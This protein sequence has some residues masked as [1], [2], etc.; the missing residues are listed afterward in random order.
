MNVGYTPAP[1]NTNQNRPTPRPGNPPLSSPP[2]GSPAAHQRPPFPGRGA[3]IRPVA[4]FSGVQRPRPINAAPQHPPAS[5]RPQGQ[6]PTMQQQQQ[7]QQQPPVANQM[8]N[9]ASIATGMQNMNLQPNPGP[10]QMLPPQVQPPHHHRAKRVYATAPEIPAVSQKS[11]LA[12]SQAPAPWPHGLSQQPQQSP[13]RPVQQPRAQQQ[14]VD[15]NIIPSQQV[16]PRVDPDQMPAP[17]QVREYDQNLHG[18]KFIGTCDREHTPLTTTDFLAMDQGNCNPRFMRSV[19]NSMPR[20]KELADVSALPMGL[21]VQPLAALARE[22]DPIQVVDHGPEGPVR[23]TRC[24]AY[25]NPWC[26]FTQGGNRF[27]CNIC[28][29]NSEVPPSYFSNLDVSG[30][31]M[32]LDQRPELKFGSVEFDVPDLYY[33]SRT[34][35]SISHLFAIDVSANAIKS[36][37]TATVCEALRKSL[38]DIDPSS[39][40]LPKDARIGIMTYDYGVHFY[41]VHPEC[42]QAK[43]L[44]VGEVADM[45]VPLQDGMLV[46]P[47]DSKDIISELLQNIPSMFA[48]NQRG[49]S[50]YSSAV[51]GGMQALSVTGGYL[52]LFQSILPSSGPGALK[53]RDDSALR[54]TDKEKQLFLPQSEVYSNLAKECVKNAV[55]VNDYLFPSAYMD[56]A[57]LGAISSTTGGETI[58]YQ[59]FGPGDF[60][61][62]L[63]DI[64][65][66]LNRQSGFDAVMRIRCTNGLQVLDHYGNFHM[67]NFTDVELAGIDED[68][69]IAISLRHD[70]R[71]EDDRGVSFQAALLYTTKDGH[72]RVRVHNLNIPVTENIADVFRQGDHEAT[73]SLLAKKAM[74]DELHIQRKEIRE[75]LSELCVK[76][77]SAY[78][79]NCASSTS[80]GQLIL[81]EAFKLLPVYIAALL[82]SK[83]LRGVGHDI[84]TDARVVD[85]KL[86]SGMS[87]RSLSIHLYPRLFSIHDATEDFLNGANPKTIRD[88]YE[89]LENTGAYLLDNGCELYFWLGSKIDSSFLQ[90]VFGVADKNE[91]DIQ[92]ANIPSLDNPLSKRLQIL[93][94]EIRASHPRYL[95]LRIVRQELDRSEFEFATNMAEDRNAEVQTYVDYMCVIHRQIQEEVKKTNYY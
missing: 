68:K 21:V 62:I 95:R 66:I 92:M 60:D 46:N 77:L 25:I 2:N 53:S 87:P 80:P 83:A 42:E 65:H 56:V 4:N 5:F 24:K 9:T 71:L 74:Y 63:Y 32:D 70:G 52:H 75:K 93:I 30:R 64:S 89:R 27:I 33:S 72:R 55:C 14:Q 78:R 79:A 11:P 20:N 38:Y 61:R 28:G 57:S 37:M 13:I 15:P 86:I 6:P 40:L 44:V 1:S 58:Y 69:A 36:G 67:N 90:Q 29:H 88:S 82:R 19:T 94:T 12:P 41:N 34:P 22:E 3:P 17:V 50:M 81:P 31:R 91:V 84:T 35:A 76:I 85:M 48:H 47:W 16:R 73:V 26:T 10:V 54:N 49:D 45:F 43:M 7:Q 18:G 23:C 8:Q 59:N 51:Q 39:S